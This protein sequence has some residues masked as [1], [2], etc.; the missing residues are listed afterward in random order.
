MESW[1]RV[2]RDGI[3]P[4][5]TTSGLLQLR[6]GLA[7]DD[8]RLTQGRV[9]SPPPLQCVLDWP[10]EGGCALTYAA[11]LAGEVRTVGEASDEFAEACFRADRRL[12]EP[13]AARYFLDWFDD[14][15]RE[16]MRRELLAEVVRALAGRPGALLLAR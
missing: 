14:T 5:M 2:W 16:E 3:S 9:C 12:R 1:R 15:T 13:G 6:R 11:W 4:G 8:P 7:E 10:V